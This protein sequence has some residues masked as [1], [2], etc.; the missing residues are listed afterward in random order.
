MTRWLERGFADRKVRGSNPTSASRLPQAWATWQYPS[1]RTFFGW[2]G[3]LPLLSRTSINFDNK[4]FGKKSL[5]LKSCDSML[6]AKQI[7]TPQDS[8]D[9]KVRD[10]NP[11][12]GSRLL[13]S[14]L[15]KL[16]VYRPSCF[17]RGARHYTGEKNGRCALRISKYEDFGGLLEPGGN[18]GSVMLKYV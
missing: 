7:L 13:P 1:P 11:T 4:Q 3:I 16:A 12:T 18:T 17:R 10:S 6:L 15:G 2:H 5:Q 14:R 9:R 8:S